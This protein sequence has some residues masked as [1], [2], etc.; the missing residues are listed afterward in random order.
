MNLL[1]TS[2]FQNSIEQAFAG[3]HSDIGGGYQDG[4]NV[5]T[6]FWMWNLAHAKG[7]PLESHQDFSKIKH[8]SSLRREVI[9]SIDK[10]INNGG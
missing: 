1:S 5:T 9:E 2:V 7:V 4:W 8:I 3:A 10:I 6:L